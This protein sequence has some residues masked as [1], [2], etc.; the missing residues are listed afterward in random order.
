MEMSH[1][2]IGLTLAFYHIS[3]KNEIQLQEILSHSGL[4]IQKQQY[5]I[6]NLSFYRS[7]IN[8]VNKWLDFLYIDEKELIEYRY[9]Y[10]Y[11]YAKIAIKLNYQSPSS[12]Y[13]KEKVILKKIERMIINE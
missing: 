7:I 13:K 12:V 6:A 3:L 2:E 11:S 5:L 1:K 4:E 9:F 10:D 8:K